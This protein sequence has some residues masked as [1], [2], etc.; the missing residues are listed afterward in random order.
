MPKVRGIKKLLDLSGSFFKHTNIQIAASH[1]RSSD[2][3]KK[4][5]CTVA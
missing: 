5:N 2:Q 1:F 3:T 4:K